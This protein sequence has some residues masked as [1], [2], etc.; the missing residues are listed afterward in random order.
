[1]AKVP[2]LS[3]IPILGNLFTWK[4]KENSIQSLI[5]LITPHLLKSTEQTDRQ[6]QKAQERNK[7]KDYFYNK[8]E[9]SKMKPPEETAPAEETKETK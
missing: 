5:I 8:Y 2:L 1:M 6:F 4:R 9:K 3:N 7:E